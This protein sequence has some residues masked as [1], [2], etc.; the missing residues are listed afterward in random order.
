MITG[1]GCFGSDGRGLYD[2]RPENPGRRA[3]DGDLPLPAF[4]KSKVWARGSGACGDGAHGTALKRQGLP[5]P[6]AG[7]LSGCRTV[8]TTGRWCGP[9]G[10]SRPSRCPVNGRPGTARPF[11]TRPVASPLCHTDVERGP[12]RSLPGSTWVRR[13]SSCD[14]SLLRDR[15]SPFPA[16]TPVSPRQPEEE[17]GRSRAGRAGGGGKQP[18]DRGRPGCPQRR[19]RPGPPARSPRRSA[20]GGAAPRRTGGQVGRQTVVTDRRTRRTSPPSPARA[21]S[22]IRS[23][24]APP[25]GGVVRP[26]P[27]V[28]A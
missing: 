19:V 24:A 26:E 17:A 14:S 18:P 11:V 2:P 16:T 25:E 6:P 1:S 20:R 21:R 15:A 13:A 12:G 10:M 3:R 8:R 4:G 27:F 7:R 23:A 22:A 5:V 9:F 28:A